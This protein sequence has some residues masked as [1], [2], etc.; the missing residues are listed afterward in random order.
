MLE[1]CTLQLVTDRIRMANIN[2]TSNINN[3]ISQSCPQK[4]LNHMSFYHTANHCLTSK[5]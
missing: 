3:I 4:L 1:S 2:Y 5:I